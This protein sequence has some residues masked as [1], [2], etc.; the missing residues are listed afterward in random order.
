MKATHMIRNTLLTGV[1]IGLLTGCS[2]LEDWPPKKS[3]MAVK[4][5]PKPP[6]SKV[7]QTSEGTWLKSDDRVSQAGP[8]GIAM[9]DAS[10]DRIAQLEQSVE[11]I[12]NDMQM[13]MPALTKLAEA[14][15]DLQ[16]ALSQVEPAAGGSM[17]ASAPPAA[18]NYAP[19]YQQ[20]QPQSYQPTPIAAQ[21]GGNVPPPIPAQFDNSR[22]AQNTY[23]QQPVM[24][25]AYQQPQQAYQP[26]PQQQMQQPPQ[27]Q[28]YQQAAMQ[29]NS[30]PQPGSVAWYEQQEQSSRQQA[31]PTNYQPAPQA[32]QPPPQQPVMQQASYGGAASGPAVTNI[33]FG[34]H[35][36][37]TR[38]VLDT[39]TDVAF[40]YNVENG[41]NV[42]SI[43]LPQSGWMG[44]TQMD[45]MNSPLVSSYSVSANGAGG[46]QVTMQMRQ[47]V[48][49]LWA[50]SLPPGG[51][52]GHRIVF[53]LAPM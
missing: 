22:P 33:R 10:S 45:V 38:M 47:P 25:Q 31:Q 13:M 52:Q 9:D 44:A 11:S 17:R 37:K 53:D 20:Q 5:A 27:Q 26:P 39:T 28:M 49:V 12:R 41:G 19:S 15:G 24:Q 48:R 36:D 42:L 16:S 50:Q 6:E 51:P 23:Q 29:Q 40:S 4:T 8:K 34:E 32:Y 18:N 14:Q 43:S 46:Q 2:W 21:G 7:M 35:P 3:E 30:G 1:C